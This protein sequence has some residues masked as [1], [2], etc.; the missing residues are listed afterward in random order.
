ME[1]NLRYFSP[2]KINLFLEV[3][4]KRKDNYHELNSL[5]CFCDVGDFIEVERSNVLKIEVVGP[6]SKK[7]SLNENIIIKTH[8][9]ISK[10]FNIENFNIR[11]FKN[12]PISSGIGGGSSNAATF[13]K[14][15]EKKLNLN[16]ETSIKNK[17]LLEIGAD[18]PVCYYQRFSI[19]SGIGD[20]IEFVPPIEESYILLVNPLIEVSTKDIFRELKVFSE[21]KTKLDEINKKDILLKKI[22]ESKNDL[23]KTAK[24]KYPVISDVLDTLSKDLNALLVR[25]S[26]SGATCFGIF[27]SQLDLDNAY[28]KI[29]EIRKNWWIKKGKILNNTKYVS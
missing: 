28:N 1:S 20:K 6:F 7:L 15:I 12:L 11:L 2:A 26:G 18:V 9:I 16:I 25:M 13:F 3:L 17:I 14:I 10:Y 27:N 5:I 19:I 22:I 21:K 8:K 23:E 4:S 24:F 29:I